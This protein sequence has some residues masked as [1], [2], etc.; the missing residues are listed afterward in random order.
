M[1]QSSKSIIINSEI[2]SDLV[3]SG[4]L[5][6]IRKSQKTR[7]AY[8]YYITPNLQLRL[9][10]G[11]IVF[12]DAK[13]I[14]FQFDKYKNMSLLKLLQHVSEVLLSRLKRS[15]DIRS[16]SIFTVH[17]EQELT[18]SIRCTLPVLSIRG[19]VSGYYIHDESEVESHQNNFRLPRVG[20]C[21]ESV[22][23][24]IRNAWENAGRL[25]F[26]VEL[27]KVKN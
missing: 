17:Q 10:G 5:K 21:Y 18:F 1:N 22:V 16:E 14:V 27:K 13:T 7:N 23:I 19:Q 20:Y 2:I 9:F 26:N 15:Y 4:E 24:E 6:I 8:N 12:C 25:G 11:K 3:N